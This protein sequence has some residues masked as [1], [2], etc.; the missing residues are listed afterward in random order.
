MT[1]ELSEKNKEEPQETDEMVQAPVPIKDSGLEIAGG[2]SS[3]TQQISDQIV[4]L[5]RSSRRNQETQRLDLNMNNPSA[6]GGAYLNRL[7]TFTSGD[8]TPTVKNADFFLTA[9][10]TAITDFDDGQVGQI[11]FIRADSSVT[12]THNA[13]IINLVGNSNFDMNSG[14]TLTLG[15]FADQVW[16]EISRMRLTSSSVQTFTSS[17]TYT[18]PAGATAVFVQAWG[19]GG[20][21]GGCNTNA[22]S[23]GGGGGA[24]REFLFPI[25]D[26][27]A[28]ET[29][30]IGAGGTAG[31]AGAND[32]GD[33]GDT[34]FGSLM[35]AFGGKKSLGGANTAIEIGG[36]GA[37]SDVANSAMGTNV[38]ADGFFGGGA[39]DQNDQGG[40]AVFGGAGG[41][42]SGVGVPKGGN[43][44]YGGGGG[45]GGY[46]GPASTATGGTSVLGGAGGDGGYGTL[47]AVGDSGNQPGGGAGGSGSNADGSKTG[48]VGGDGQLIATTY[49]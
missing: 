9:G 13:S 35:T 16:H 33:G 19:A 42:G 5:P 26:V 2:F 29:V 46:A 4:V 45:G 32:G 18:K 3:S 6:Y 31:A 1:D 11:L 22:D 24:Y 12:I 39:G 36:A 38:D 41:S 27:G 40:D 14:D 28:T 34:T 7:V 47:T 30:T 8:A 49:F 44:Q 25:G 15:M 23:G 17:G 20:G 48:A 10:T 43:C 37:G 21:S